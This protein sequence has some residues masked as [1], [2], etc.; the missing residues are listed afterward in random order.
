MISIQNRITALVKLGDFLGQFSIEKIEKRDN[1]EHNELFF[2]G[3]LH[4]I[5]IAQES[6]SWFTK[7]NILFALN[8]IS[9]SLTYNSLDLFVKSVSLNII[10]SKKVA[11]IM[12][13][14]IP[15]VGFHDFLS[16]LISGHSVLVKQSSND[17]HLL[18]FLAKYLEH[19]EENF[20]GKITFTEEK[21]TDFDAVI[22][23]GSDNTARYFEFY[24]KN[25]PNI[26]R[27]SRNSVAIITGKE[28]EQDFIKLSDD[29]FQY[30]GLGCRSVSKLYVPKDYNFDMFFAGM[31]SKKD[32]IHNA[33]YANNYDYNKAVYLMSLYDLL[34]N[35]FL[36]IKED[37]SYSSPI[38]TIFYEYYENEID[39]KIKLHQDKEKIQCIVAKDFI[40]NEVGF[41]QTQSPK[42]TDYADG[43]NT[44]EFLTKI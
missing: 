25:K 1:I 33:K 6:N 43:V 39:L 34:E 26:I 11:V 32:M 37:K 41:G 3:F 20:K 27:K 2:E 21:L 12:A 23:T 22:A 40:E 44:L 42:L 24:F 15:L 13:G 29:V 4:Q 35:G 31:Y 7:N 28:T 30:F 36:M 5:K 18:P 38:A 9:K 17:K 16:V 14:N 10:S 19:I 8:S